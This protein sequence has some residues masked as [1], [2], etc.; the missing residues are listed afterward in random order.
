MLNAFHKMGCDVLYVHPDEEGDLPFRNFDNDKLMTQVMINEHN[1]PLTT[2][3]EGERLIR[4]STIAY[5]AS[6]EIEEVIYNEEVGLFKPWQFESYSTQP[7]TLKTTLDELKILWTEPAKL[8]PEFKVQNKKVY[9]PNMFAKINGVSEDLNSYWLDL[10]AL[11]ST[12]NTRL[13]EDVLLLK[14]VTLNKS[15]IRRVIY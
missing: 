14:S 4:K 9:V 10:K 1:L 11:S 5:K 12:S 15:F 13:L 8:R 6:K 3:P 2:F 7:I